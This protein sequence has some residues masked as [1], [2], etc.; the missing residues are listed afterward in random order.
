MCCPRRASPDSTSF[1]ASRP[2]LTKNEVALASSH[3]V[4][5]FGKKTPLVPKS[6]G[7]YGAITKDMEARRKIYQVVSKAAKAVG[8]KAIAFAHILARQ[9]L[10]FFR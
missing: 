5:G 1:L 4:V 2:G 9:R 10:A 3:D 7:C 6:I 8:D